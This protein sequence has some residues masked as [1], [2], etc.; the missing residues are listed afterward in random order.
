VT[1]LIGFLLGGFG[2]FLGVVVGVGL[3]YIF[4][5]LSWAIVAGVVMGILT[6]TPF[7]MSAAVVSTYTATAYHTCLYLWARDVERS[8]QAG[9]DVPVTAPRPL[10][11]VLE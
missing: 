4:N 7:L 2:I 10:A 8:Q 5:G 9:L 3:A 6:A 1:S 11:A